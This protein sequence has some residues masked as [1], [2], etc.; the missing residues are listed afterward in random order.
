MIAGKLTCPHCNQLIELSATKAPPQ[1]SS[2]PAPSAGKNAGEETKRLLDIIT[3]CVMMGG[4]LTDKEDDMY[5]TT[6]DRYE[7]WGDKIF[8]NDKQMVFLRNIAQKVGTD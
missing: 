8:M 3:D 4:K 7:E 5:R 1:Q 6:R 2:R